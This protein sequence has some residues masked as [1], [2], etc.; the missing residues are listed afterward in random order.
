MS[1]ELKPA[2]HTLRL[3]QSGGTLQVLL[4]DFSVKGVQE[5]ELCSRGGRTVLSLKIIVEKS[6]VSYEISD[7]MKRE[8][9]MREIKSIAEKYCR[10]LEK[11]LDSMDEN[12]NL[13]AEELAKANDC[14]R[15]LGNLSVMKERGE[16]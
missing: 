4:D 11:A 2:I 15:V 5:Y 14:V 3:A 7:E 10:L 9:K 16:F 13:T 8:N 1:E 6:K 12:P